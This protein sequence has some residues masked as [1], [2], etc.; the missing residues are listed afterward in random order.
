MV[1]SAVCVCV[2]VSSHRF[3]WVFL[4]LWMHLCLHL[5]SICAQ[6]PK[7]APAGDFLH[8]FGSGWMYSVVLLTVCLSVRVSML[9]YARPFTLSLDKDLSR[10]A[11]QQPAKCE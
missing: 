3:D 4:R 1:S 2:C 7:L 10:S 9:S 5:G 11:V 6:S 8:A